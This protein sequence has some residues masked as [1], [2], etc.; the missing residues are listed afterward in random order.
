M[1]HLHKMLAVKVEA[2]EEESEEAGRTVM[3]GTVV[4]ENTG[5]V[6]LWC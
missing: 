6:A 4:V 1:T 2:K 3:L 5:A